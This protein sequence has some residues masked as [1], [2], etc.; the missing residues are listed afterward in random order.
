MSD[1]PVPSTNPAP[2]N[3]A[4]EEQ[5][6]ELAHDL[7]AA[8]IVLTRRIRHQ[9]VA[10]L[11]PHLLSVLARAA[12]GPQ[13]ASDLAQDEQ[14]SAPAMSRS[15]A[16]LERRG[17]VQ[18]QVDQQ[19]RRVRVVETTERG[20]ELLAQVRTTRDAWLGQALQQ[21]PDDDRQV[22]RRATELLEQ[23]AQH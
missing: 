17:M 7:R 10:P 22:L 20:R 18:R 1:A 9:H 5:H 2:E 23:L 15:L 21:L 4:P 11:S 6:L 14:V 12:E 16:E 3:P 13:S 19:D 8:C